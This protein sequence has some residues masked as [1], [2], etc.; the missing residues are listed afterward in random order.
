MRRL[1][2]GVGLGSKVWIILGSLA[3]VSLL[4]FQN[5]GQ[6]YHANREPAVTDP[7]GKV[8][9]LKTE[10]GCV[11]LTGDGLSPCTTININTGCHSTANPAIL[12]NASPPVCL[13]ANGSLDFEIDILTD[14]IDCGL[15]IDTQVSACSANG[16]AGV[17]S[18]VKVTKGTNQIA[19][20]CHID[21]FDR[22]DSTMANLSA[23]V[24]FTD[25]NTVTGPT[26]E[27]TSAVRGVE[28]CQN[29]DGSSK[30]PPLLPPPASPTATQEPQSVVVT[31]NPALKPIPSSTTTAPTTANPPPPVSEDANCNQGFQQAHCLNLFP[32]CKSHQDSDGVHWYGSNC[33]IFAN[34]GGDTSS[35]PDPNSCTSIHGSGWGTEGGCEKQNNHSCNT[36][37]NHRFYPDD[38]TCPNI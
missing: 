8:T 24:T 2:E 3:F 33:P 5:C 16:Q 14:N 27:K 34:G 31:S 7:S 21:S 25:Q 15:P 11:N 35:G 30:N 28:Y 1:F 4:A 36:V 19:V 10:D 9:Q 13:S 6:G 26:P 23:N 38:C 22:G 12:A 20:N 32:E 29:G 18:S 17:P 37:C